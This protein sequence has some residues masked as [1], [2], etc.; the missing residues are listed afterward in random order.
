MT[1][2]H[3]YARVLCAFL[4]LAAS[5]ATTAG[6]PERSI[7]FIVPTTPGGGADTI[8][9]HIATR[10][11]DHWVQQV[12]VDNRPGA[13]GIIGVDAA[14]KANPDGMEKST[15]AWPG[16]LS[17][18]FAENE[19]RCLW[20]PF[21]VDRGYSTEVTTV[22]VVATRGIYPVTK[23]VQK[24][25]T[26]VLETIAISMHM[27]GAPIY[28]QMDVPVVVCL[29]PEHAAE[30]AH[31]GYSKRDVRNY[32]FEHCRL[33]VGL[34]RGRGYYAPGCWPAALNEQDD[35]VLVPMVSTPDHF[36]IVVAGGDGRHSAWMPVWN[37][38]RGATELVVL[39][40]D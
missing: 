24:T 17:M 23:G 7:R 20:E 11:T 1:E 25:G 33:P 34:L 35:E 3:Q 12:I 36:W 6:Y 28:Y 19:S 30:I 15:L 27:V 37:V 31:A 39:G 29:G 8:A 22:S 13:N 21:R 38:C 10:L 4:A 9:R 18:C 5:A 16:K 26:D 2:I 40:P 14:A 32:L